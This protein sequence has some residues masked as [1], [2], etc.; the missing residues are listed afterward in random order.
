MKGC[1]VEFLTAHLRSH[2]ESL[3]QRTDV[4]IFMKYDSEVK[5]GP[6]SVKFPC[7]AGYPRALVQSTVI[8]VTCRPLKKAMH[9]VS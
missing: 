8:F 4:K 1:Y 9:L 6:N 2:L 3:V 7:P 5:K